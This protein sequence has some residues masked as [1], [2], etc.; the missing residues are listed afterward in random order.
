MPT[1]SRYLHLPG[2]FTGDCVYNRTTAK[3]AVNRVAEVYVEVC[4]DNGFSLP[5]WRADYLAGKIL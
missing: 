4:R 2:M 3:E 5:S 1:G